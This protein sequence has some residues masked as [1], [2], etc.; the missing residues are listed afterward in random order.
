MTPKKEAMCE[1]KEPTQLLLFIIHSLCLCIPIQGYEEA[2]ATY[3]MSTHKSFFYPGQ[4][5]S[6]VN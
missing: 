5:A 4:H 1:V 2:E 6:P 3:M